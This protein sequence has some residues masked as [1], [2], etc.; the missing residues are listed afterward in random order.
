MLGEVFVESGI[1][2]LLEEIPFDLIVPIGSL[3]R[4][5]RPQLAGET[6][7]LEVGTTVI[8]AMHRL[9][10]ACRSFTRPHPLGFRPAESGPPRLDGRHA[11][12]QSQAHRGPALGHRERRQF[13]K[14]R[15]RFLRVA[16]R[17]I[18]HDSWGSRQG[19]EHLAE[20]VDA[21]S[22][23]QVLMGWFPDN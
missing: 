22:E 9:R 1:E 13:E 16:R 7:G 4:R 10:N 15:Y 20:A 14:L 23:E 3:Y 19:I 17:L 11:H 5:R 2:S 12:C 6:A 8:E 21:G 18:I